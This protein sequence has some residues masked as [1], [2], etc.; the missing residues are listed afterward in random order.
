LIVL[1]LLVAAVGGI[2]LLLERVPGLGRLP[3][4]I[5]VQRGNFRLYAPIATSLLLSLLLTFL[6][7]LLA[8]K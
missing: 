2:L 5:L 4:D 7:N 1:G 3:G 6:L 8:R